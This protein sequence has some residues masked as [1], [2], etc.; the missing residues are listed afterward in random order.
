MTGIL[1]KKS[2]ENDSRH[3]A[4]SVRERVNHDELV[5]VAR[6]KCIRVTLPRHLGLH[7]FVVQVLD[8]YRHIAWDSRRSYAKTCLLLLLVPGAVIVNRHFIGAILSRHNVVVDPLVE[9]P[10]CL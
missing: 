5:V 10:V 9:D 2:I 3:T 8:Y 1:E 4:V 7:K 6:R